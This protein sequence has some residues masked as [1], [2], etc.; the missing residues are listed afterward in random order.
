[1][2]QSAF[3]CSLQSPSGHR[4][5]DR[6]AVVVLVGD[7]PGV[8]VARDH[9]HLQDD[10]RLGAHRQERAVG[11]APFFAQG[12]QDDAHDPVVVPQ[13]VQERRVELAFLVALGRALELVLEAE[14]VEKG[15]EP[16]VVVGAE[17]VMG[18][19]RI[20]DRGQ[21]LAQMLRQH[22]M[23]RHVVGYLAQAVHVVGEGEQPRRHVAQ[24]LERLAHHGRAHDLAEGADMGQ[25]GRAVAR[26]EQDVA[27]LG[28]LALDALQQLARFVEGPGLGLHG[29]RPQIGRRSRR[30]GFA[31]HRSGIHLQG[32]DRA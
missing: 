3:H 4:G 11:L 25:A 17:A 21:G 23:V 1:M 9:R 29:Q 14:F 27:L 12:R 16:R 28:R 20:R 15:L 26:L 30:T 13:N 10:A 6:F 8:L 5:L 2:A 32:R 7:G 19:E 31:G 22:L 24:P 18:A